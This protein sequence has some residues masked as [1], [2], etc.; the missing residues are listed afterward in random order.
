MVKTAIHRLAVGGAGNFARPF[1]GFHH[2]IVA[3]GGRRR[4]TKLRQRVNHNRGRDA[5]VIL[6]FARHKG[7]T[8]IAEIVEHRA[9]T[10]AAPRQTN[11]IFLHPARVALF[12][13]VL[14]PA[15]YDGI[16]VAPEEQHALGGRHLAEDALFHR[17]VKPGIVRIGNKQA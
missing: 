15:N 2:Q 14:R 1:G 8:G 5:F 4:N 3:P 11:V 12:P 13:R 16:G 17:Q 6:R 7:K 10:A 9:A